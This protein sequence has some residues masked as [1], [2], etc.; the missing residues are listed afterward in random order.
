MSCSSWDPI[1]QDHGHSTSRTWNLVC[2]QRWCLCCSLFSCFPS[3]SGPLMS[4]V[5]RPCLLLVWAFGFDAQSISLDLVG[6][7]EFQ[8]LTP[9]F[10]SSFAPQVVCV[11]IKFGK[12]CFSFSQDPVWGQ[13]FLV[14]VFKSWTA[15][16]RIL[17]GQNTQL[18]RFS[19]LPPGIPLAVFPFPCSPSPPLPPLPGTQTGQVQLCSSLLLSPGHYPPVLAINPWTPLG[20]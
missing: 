6:N 7:A 13:T 20:A 4:S 3:T 5:V 2:P 9:T 8:T 11:H 10:E 18:F 15:G 14:S 16:I 12:H 17:T 1:Q 19:F